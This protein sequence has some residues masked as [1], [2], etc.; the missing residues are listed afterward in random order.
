MVLLLLQRDGESGTDA[1]VSRLPFCI[2]SGIMSRR[3]MNGLMLGLARR[4]SRDRFV[5]VLLEFAL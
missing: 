4:R 1:A 3:P 2:I 5:R